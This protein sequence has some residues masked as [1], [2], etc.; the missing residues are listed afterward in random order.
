MLKYYCFFC[1]FVFFSGTLCLYVMLS[2]NTSEEDVE[3]ELN[4]YCEVAIV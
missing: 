2:A 3:L 4:F 1:F